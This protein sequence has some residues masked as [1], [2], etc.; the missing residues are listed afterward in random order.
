MHPFIVA[1]LAL[2]SLR[3]RR[4]TFSLMESL[5]MVRVA[6]LDEIRQMI[7]PQRLCSR[8]LGLTDV[9]LLASCLLTPGVQLWTCDTSLERAAFAVGVRATLP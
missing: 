1:E 6:H 7:E 8:G 9:Q 4:E 3:N 2:G 5:W